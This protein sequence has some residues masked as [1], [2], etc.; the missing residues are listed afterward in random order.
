[1]TRYKADISMALIVIVWGLHYIVVKD[2]I[3][4]FAP[5][6][7][8]AIRFSLG[9][10]ILLAFGLRRLSKIAREDVVRL[11]LLGL[12]GPFGYQIFFILGI[13]RTTSTNTALLLATMPMWTAVL[14]IFMG[15]VM[16]R[17]Q[18]IM[19]VILSL[20]GV[21]L[22]VLVSESGGVALSATDLLGS[23]FALGAA[24]TSAYYNIGIKPLVDRYGGTT[25]AMW[26][27]IIT[28][29]GLWIVSAP[30]L[31]QIGPGDIPG[32]IWPNLIYSGVLSCAFGFLVESYAIAHIGPA[33]VSH[34]YNITPLVAAV[35]GVVLLG[36]P[37]TVVLVI[38]AA[39]T[40]GGSVI[41][42]RNTYLKLPKGEPLKQTQETSVRAE[43]CV[44][45]G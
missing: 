9:L 37:F 26:T 10:P 29:V 14:T 43:A 11:L 28:A 6:T 30:D 2:A 42:R 35:G 20:I 18:M 12:I 13:E 39:L 22:V 3:D 41:T 36:E 19:G 32:H 31:V 4:D 24:I 1:M 23:G 15:I 7:F 21:V 38:G 44:E 16:I 34:Y 8:N 25:I 5:L 33:R 27:Y 17:R 40:L 45:V